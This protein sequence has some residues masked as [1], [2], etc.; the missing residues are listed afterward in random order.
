M[1]G[2]PSGAPGR[3]HG[4]PPSGSV[5]ATDG[6]SQEKTALRFLSRGLEKLRGSLRLGRALRLVW[7]S[8]PRWTVLSLGLVLVQAVLPLV[9]LYL[10]KLVVDA[11]AAGVGGEAPFRSVLLYIGL[12]ALAGLLSAAAGSA[13][14][15]IGE[16]QGHLVTDHIL[17]VIHEK[18][19]A[20][21]LGY[22]ED[23]QY[24]DT[25]HRAQQQA[26]YRPA[27]VLN[28]LLQLAR[29]G[30]TV[31]GIVILLATVH[32]LLAALLFVAVVPALLV[33]LRHADRTYRW[34]L[35]RASTERQ[36]SYFS[37]ILVNPILAKEVRTFGLG[38]PLI[39]TFRDLR[40]TLRGEKIELS[41]R[42]VT[43]ELGAQ[44]LG[45]AAVFASFGIIAF[46]TLQGT[47]TLGDLVMYFGAVQKGQSLL[48]GLF[49]ALGGL[50]EDNL[51]LSLLDD[52]LGVEPRITAPADPRPVPTPPRQG[53][54]FE[55]VSFRYPGSSRPLLA[56]VALELRPGE[57]VALVGPN[58]AG[59]TTIVKLLCRL[60]DPD[61]GRITL[62]GIDL[63]DF[64]PHE[65]RRLLAVVFQDFG[66][67]H[68]TAREN[69]RLGNVRREPQG[70]W[71][72]E[73]ARTAGA[74]QVIR[75][76]RHGYDTVLGRLF[77]NG[78]ELSI[79][80]WQKV[81]LARAFASEGHVLVV[82][83]P[84]S[85]LDAAAE[86]EFFGTLRRLVHDRSA[87][88]ISHRFST[89]RMAD[90]IYVLDGGGI[91]ESG[92]HDELMERGGMYARLFGLQ[93]APYQADGTTDRTL[94]AAR[95]FGG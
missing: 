94:D 39:D 62:D 42:R 32:W 28:G 81:A 73:A 68:F 9:T 88:L 24:H 69:I 34:Q 90:R 23:P 48:G 82:D 66:C 27:K 45:A 95:P 67:Y 16:A 14:T 60:Y 70:D 2:D 61:G 50:Y 80:E 49:G 15:L 87:L 54:V 83:E 92:S 3:Q 52:F 19:V 65:Y 11:V 33:R 85:A 35:H 55:E 40:A 71:I 57:V 17:E 78:E 56:G 59:K 79:G 10:T 75:R 20:A 37:W 46:Q 51:F 25:L 7:E 5:V 86:A 21:D 47:L 58:G 31:V 4:A 53:L 6:T 41:R 29:T 13:A 12:A 26:P 1:H 43:G 74:D 44:A 8:S 76:L 18:S 63:R 77:E 89:V 22:Y 36:A 84:T 72:E 91:V 64:D 93:A 38:R 30:L